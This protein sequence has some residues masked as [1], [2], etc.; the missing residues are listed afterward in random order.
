MKAV[1]TAVILMSVLIVAGF[2]FV[3]YTIAA[4]MMSGEPVLPPSSAGSSQEDIATSFGEVDLPV[5]VGCDLE[6][7]QLEGNR[8]LIT[9]D[10]LDDQRCKQ[11]IVMDALSGET[12][13]RVTLRPVE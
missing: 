9:L 8:L 12:L 7:V 2:G 6:S 4:R 13:G 10:G 3:I 11:V 1:K 5:P